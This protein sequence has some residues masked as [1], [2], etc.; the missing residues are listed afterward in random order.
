MLVALFGRVMEYPAIPLFFVTILIAIVW[1]LFE[2]RINIREERINV[3]SDIF[4]PL[5]AYIVTLWLVGS[6][7]TNHEQRVALLI[8]TIIFYSLVSYAA[9]RARFDQDPDFLD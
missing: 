4:M 6:E 8:V 5:L 2:M 9:W 7:R 3:A 1:E